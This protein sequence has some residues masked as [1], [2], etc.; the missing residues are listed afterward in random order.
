[1]KE[2]QSLSHTRVG[3][4]VPRCVYPE[5]AEEADFRGVAAATG[6]D[7]RWDWTKR[8]SAHTSGI[9]RRK[10]SGTTKCG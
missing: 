3:L 7:F 8:W 5:A 1:M 6:G 2:Y 4:Q 9:K 10:T